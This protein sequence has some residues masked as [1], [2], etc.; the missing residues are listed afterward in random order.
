MSDSIINKINTYYTKKVIDNGTSSQG[1]DWN[2]RESH[3]LRFA[4]LSKVLESNKDFSILDFGCGYGALID[5]LNENEFVDYEYYGY[6]ISEE[7]IK[8]G[9]MA[10]NASGI[11]FE[12][13]LSHFGKQKYDYTIANG[14]FNVKLD[15]PEVAWK[16]YIIETINKINDVTT[17]GFSFNVLT[18]YSDAEM[19]KDYLH[20]AN[21]LELFDYCKRNFSKKVA[22]LHDYPLYEFTII[23]R[24]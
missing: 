2:S 6:D 19:M 5:F 13:N 20:Y 15:T 3:F 11:Q 24:K 23:V 18:S 7:M 21:P 14:I 16:D 8:R 10:Y 22:L 17:K 12:T 9:R 4:Q 1:V